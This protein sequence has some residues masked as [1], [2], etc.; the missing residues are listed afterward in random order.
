MREIDWFTLSDEW[1]L[2]VRESVITELMIHMTASDGGVIS[3][4][5]IRSCLFWWSPAEKAC[6]WVIPQYSQMFLYV[7]DVMH[8][9]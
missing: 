8:D 9:H 1:V 7:S 6:L 3:T 5:M 4:S 2:Q